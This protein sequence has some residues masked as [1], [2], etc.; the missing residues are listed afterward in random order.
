MKTKK[1][2]VLRPLAGE[3]IVTGEGLEQVNFNK[4][5]SL[6]PSA[7][8]LW[9]QIEGRE[10]DQQALADLLVKK[11]AIDP[12]TAR[13]DASELIDAWEKAGLIE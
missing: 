3:Q 5:I 12:E 2:F 11:Y 10:F 13:A 9:E 7:A 8:Y 1:G 6:N 4:L